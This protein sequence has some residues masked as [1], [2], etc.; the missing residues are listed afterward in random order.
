[1]DLFP[2]NQCKRPQYY[3]GN[4]NKM[5]TNGKW[6]NLTTPDDNTARDREISR[7]SSRKLKALFFSLFPVDGT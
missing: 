3:E 1:M 7:N 5:A 2:C 6:N 4:Y